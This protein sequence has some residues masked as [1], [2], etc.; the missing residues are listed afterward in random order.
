MFFNF[1]MVLFGGMTVCYAGFL[2]V[3]WSTKGDRKSIAA[4]HA[5]GAF[6]V[7]SDPSVMLAYRN[8]KN[9]Y[10][11]IGF[12]SLPRMIASITFA[13]CRLNIF[14]GFWDGPL[15]ASTTL[16][17]TTAM[18]MFALYNLASSL[19]TYVNTKDPN[20]NNL[21]LQGWKKFC[22]NYFL[23]GNMDESLALIRVFCIG[24]SL[25][26]RVVAGACPE[27]TTFLA[28]AQCNPMA[29]SKGLPVDH[30]LFL[31]FLPI[32]MPLSLKG[33]RF[34]ATI[35]VWFVS[36]GWIFASIHH[37]GGQLEIVTAVIVVVPLSVAFELER[38]LRLS[39]LNLELAEERTKAM[40]LVRLLLLLFAVHFVWCVGLWS[41]VVFSKP[42]DTT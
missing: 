23:N 25:Y 27:D 42:S 22:L 29:A 7:F 11:G 34:E 18:C 2:Y 1:Y 39:F 31:S 40:L 13:S 16:L 28:I 38:M 4:Q 9:N 24:L 21:P 35:F 12:V 8:Y 33:M 32:I 14:S 30:V 19:V 10:K 26:A 3:M 41:S 17:A 6:P 15:F 20:G 37:M 5:I 36:V